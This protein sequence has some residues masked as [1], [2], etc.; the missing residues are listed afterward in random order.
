M[1][2]YPAIYRRTL[3]EA[4]TAGDME[5]YRAS[6]KENIACC[7]AIDEAIRNNFDGMHLNGNTADGVIEKYGIDRVVYVLAN[8]LQQKEYD[9][10]FS[11]VNKDWA[12]ETDVPDGKNNYEFCSD[13]HPAI[14][15][16]FCDMVRKTQREL[17][18]PSIKK[19]L[20]EL[21]E[22]KQSMQSTRAVPPK[23]KGAR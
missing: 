3:D 14:L 9:G 2:N 4:K 17:Q 11:S 21:S 10:R 8:T 6:H 22:Q 18:K 7:K 1:K 13:A 5:L 19:K 12:S 20:A 23:D 15:D 16:G